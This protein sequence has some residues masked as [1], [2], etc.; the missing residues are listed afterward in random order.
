MFY[1][2]NSLIK[3]HTKKAYTA[4]SDIE[5]KQPNF[6]IVFFKEVKAKPAPVNTLI[7][8]CERKGVFT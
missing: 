6:K 4:K 3:E 8:V 2:K 5:R 7:K 1:S